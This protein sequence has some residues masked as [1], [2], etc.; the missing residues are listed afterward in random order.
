MIYA[1]LATIF[2][3]EII[4]DVYRHQN[5]LVTLTDKQNARSKYIKGF[6]IVAGLMLLYLLTYQIYGWLE[7]VYPILAYLAVRALLFD[8]LYWLFKDGELKSLKFLREKYWLDI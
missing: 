5:N 3:T 6:G 4:H 7:G 2:L 8:V 1:L